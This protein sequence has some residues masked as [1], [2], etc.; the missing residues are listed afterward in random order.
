[1]Q[2]AQSRAGLPDGFFSDQ[3]FLIWVHYGG[4]WN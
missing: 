2:K 4:R 1:M 3:K